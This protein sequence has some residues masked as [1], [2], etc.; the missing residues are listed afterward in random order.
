MPSKPKRTKVV[1]DPSSELDS[2]GS[3]ERVMWELDRFTDD[4][5]VKWLRVYWHDY[6]SS[7]KCRLFPIEYVNNTLANGQ[8]LTISISTTSLGMLPMDVLIPGITPS[9]AY[10]LHPDWSSVKLG[11]VKGHISGYGEFRNP[12]GTEVALCPRT[13]LRHTVE[14]AATHK[15]RYIIGFEIQFVIMERNPDITSGEKYL[16]L[17]ND[18]H[19]WSSARAL[20]DWGRPGAF[21]TLV[22][23]II[24]TLQFAGIFIQQFNAES[25]PG[26][27]E[28]ILPPVPPL[29]ACD[30]LLHARQ[31]IESISA[32]HGYRITLHP[33]PFAEAHG[34]ASHVHMSLSSAGGNDPAVYESFYAGILKHLRAICA[35]TNSHPA[36]YARMADGFCAGGR[37]VTWS[38]KN[39][40]TPLRKCED[41][42]W[43]LKLMDGLAN[44]YIAM[45]AILA[46]G[47]N[48][49]INKTAMTW[50][51]CTVDP[52][53]LSDRQRKKL[54]ISEMLPANLKQA[55][56]A[57]KADKELIDLLHPEMVQ[58]YIDVKSAEIA[59]LELMGSFERRQ[60]ILE[61]Y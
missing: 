27:Y 48:G 5:N 45:S 41:G 40:E 31:I 44:P 28:L 34:T 47:T 2:A 29:E 12:D 25:A 52:A 43:E 38:T 35:F 19:A 32:R 39:G 59:L 60:W 50:S 33:K 53:V 6:T 11:P 56:E 13:L 54:G 23:E 15:L 37:W 1:R 7:A 24:D 9:G 30:T 58:R 14:T 4:D 49:I 51:D 22:D 18:G 16:P 61:R 46:A 21:I 10:I 57:L 42:H 36:S 3:P 26:Q 8:H 20:A 55:L 17:R